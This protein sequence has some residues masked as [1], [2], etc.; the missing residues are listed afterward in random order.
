[1]ARERVPH[2]AHD[3]RNGQYHLNRIEEPN[4]V[5]LPPDAHGT[6]DW[7]S[8]DGEL[9]YNGIRLPKQWPPHT[10]NP[11]CLEPMPLPYLEH[12]PEVIPIDVG[13]QL[14]V[15]DF[16]R[17]V[18][19]SLPCKGMG[20][21]PGAS[22][23]GG[24]RHVANAPCKG[25]GS[26]P[27]SFQDGDHR[28]P[29]SLGL[30]PKASRLR[31]FAAARRRSAAILLFVSALLV[32]TIQ[33]A[34]V[35][36]FETAEGRLG[37]EAG[38][39]ARLDVAAERYKSGRRSLRWS[40]TQSRATLT[41]RNAS[42]FVGLKAGS[43]RKGGSTI[44]LWVYNERPVPGRLHVELL[45]REQT[46]GTFWFHVS[47]RGWRPLGA[48]YNQV[49]WT[50]GQ[51]VDAV[52]FIAPKGLDAGRLYLD[53][54]CFDLQSKGP[55]PD[56]QQ[57]WAGTPDRLQQEGGLPYSGRDV[58]LSR[59]WLPLLTPPDQIAPEQL[60]EMDLLSQ[61]AFSR[62]AFRRA[63]DPGSI[64]DLRGEL[65]QFE[66]RRSDGALTGRAISLG[67]FHDGIPGAVPFMT[68]ADTLRKV[69]ALYLKAKQTKDEATV[70]EARQMFFDLCDHLLDQGGA[71]GNANVGGLGGGYGLRHWPPQVMDL[72]RELAATGRLR[73]MALTVAWYSGGSIMLAEKP[74]FS[75]DT[76]SNALRNLPATILM[77]PDPSERLQRL[78][79]LQ[80]LFNVVFADNLPFAPD[81]TVHHHWMHHMAYASYSMPAAFGIFDLLRDT[82]FRLDR[83][84]HERLKT[85][86][87]ANTFAAN[88]YT[89][90]PNLNGRAGTPLKFNPEALA[91]M[92]AHAGTPDGTQA[93]DPQMAGI[94]LYLVDDSADETAKEL[95]AKGF[96][97]LRP[98]GHWT[99]NGTCAA[100]HRRD[101]WLV[102]IDGMNRFRR[103][104][105]IYGWIESNNYGRYTCNGSV[106]VL[107]TGDP[108]SVYDS[109]YSY[110]GWNW[111]HWPGTTS[112]VRSSHELYDYYTM[113]GNPTTFAGGTHLAGDGI[114]GMD[115]QGRDVH[116]CKSAFCFD[117]RITVITTSIRTEKDR[118]AVT[119]LFQNVMADRPEPICINGESVSAF[120]LD[121]QLVGDR[122]N[123][124]ID[125]KRTGYYL[126]P[127][128]ETV[129]VQRHTQQWTY[130][131]TRFLKDPN[132]NPFTRKGTRGRFRHKN[133]A[134]NER[135]YKPTSA[136]FVLAY[137]DH[138]LKPTNASCAYTLIVETTPK[139]MADFGSAMT[140]PETAHYRIL[141]R[142]DTAHIIHDRLSDT[143]AYVLF[144][145]HDELEDRGCL[146]ANSRPCCAMIRQDGE[147][148]LL[149]VASSDIALQD[150]ITLRLRGRWSIG[151]AAAPPDPK[152]FQEKGQTV[153]E[154]PYDHYMP[155]QV[156]LARAH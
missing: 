38:Q 99:L 133:R 115:F 111:N 84:V 154:L 98:T 4:E 62:I 23:P 74:T 126:H 92:M 118:P 45:D 75:T 127:G 16:L 50:E 68:W 119:T 49:G 87:Y 28:R 13:R 105:E 31:C 64:H 1:M 142:D 9:L 155:M 124:L 40:W 94:Y 86:V 93:I 156:T 59:P 83:N 37:W 82:S 70:S 135:Y 109:G 2:S 35:H 32:G 52:R 108:V 39:G 89:I 153:L 44:A 56:S 25:A 88:K 85:Y 128:H 110:D 20:V 78:Q 106:L 12:S 7:A 121:R 103:G 139:S 104:M 14:F 72:R 122:P 61:R 100:L 146:L 123:W 22:A 145:A 27:P 77:L 132:D 144:A 15:D 102:A 95:R 41:Y 71:E 63:L 136:D 91:R 42:D 29:E 143:T 150:P 129:H 46:V 80:R 79:A 24:R 34:T 112:L 148:L 73:D 66:I 60:K 36:D 48:R 54:V 141:Q 113:Y 76:L 149:S 58:S 101:H 107:S 55:R 33:A 11:N 134:D 26:P 114:W 53:Y 151:E 69:G 5:D 120:P 8:N 67:G 65:A 140:G 18:G 6:Y 21:E 90:P 19:V 51:K 43:D 131:L 138:G 81:G 3:T 147:Q 117:N 125:N 130:M 97:P 116:F 30:K 137:I 96:K 17:G 47:Y 152:A 57:P 10:Q